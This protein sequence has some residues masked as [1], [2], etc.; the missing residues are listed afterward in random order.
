MYII[1]HFTKENFALLISI[2]AIVLAWRSNNISKNTLHI[3]RYDFKREFFLGASKLKEIVYLVNKIS[4]VNPSNISK[5][6]FENDK[7]IFK[8]ILEKYYENEE[9]ITKAS[10]AIPN[11]VFEQKKIFEKLQANFDGKSELEIYTP[12]IEKII[13]YG[14]LFF[15]FSLFCS[16]LSLGEGE[17]TNEEERKLYVNLLKLYYEFNQ[18]KTQVMEAKFQ[19]SFEELRNIGEALKQ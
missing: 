13:N 6:N 4:N 3:T 16:P 11:L 18:C 9:K 10:Y 19:E 5:D 2:G 12:D 17:S 14:R 7:L 1:Q 8:E 15:N